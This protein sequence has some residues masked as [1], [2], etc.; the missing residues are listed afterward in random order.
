MDEQ[1]NLPPPNEHN[2]YQTN[3]MQPHQCGEQTM[4]NN[5]Y[6]SNSTAAVTSVDIDN[7]IWDLRVTKKLKN[8]LNALVLEE[9]KRRDG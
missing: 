6:A 5:N 9:P 4:A 8:Q 3:T 1:E 2:Q 7:T